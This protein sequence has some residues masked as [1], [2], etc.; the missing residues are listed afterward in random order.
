MEKSRTAGL[1]LVI[2]FLVSF[3][4]VLGLRFWSSGESAEI[5]GPVH[6]AAGAAGV[7]VAANDELFVLSSAGD[8]RAR[9]RMASLM[10]PRQLIDL[11][12]LRDGR[13]LL[14]RR[15]P[16]A[17]YACEL[18]RWKCRELL[19]PV[20][21]HLR[22]QYKVWPDENANRLLISDFS[23]GQLWS[24]PLSG[25]APEALTEKG[26][27][28]G[29]N[30][31]ALDG[32]GRLW[33]ADSAGRRLV[34]LEP[35][36]TGAWQIEKHLSARSAIA[37]EN[38]NWPMMLALAPDGNWWVTQP[39]PDSRQADLLIY[40][41]DKGVSARV[42][43]PAEAYPTDV[44]AQG[45]SMLVTDMDNFRVY[46]VDVATRK[47]GEFGDANF[48]GALQQ[49]A[50]RKTRYQAWSDQ[51]LIGAIVFGVLMVAAAV[52][53]TPKDKRWS[54]REST[55]PL[56][57]SSAP[58]PALQTIHWL[59]RNP[60]TARTLRWILPMSYAAVVLAIAAFAAIYFDLFPGGQHE[61]SPEKLR[62]L[63]ELKSQLLLLA[64]LMAGV[65]IL[66]HL[67]VRN[68]QRRLGTNG[69]ALFVKFTDGRQLSLAP[70]QLVYDNRQ[71]CY[72]DC[73][74]PIRTGKQQPLYEAGEIETFVAPL[75]ARARKLDALQMLRYQFVNREP[76][77]IAA[78]L[79][80]AVLGFFLAA[81]GAW[82]KLIPGLS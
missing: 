47:V 29:P 81:T 32:S 2:L 63:A 33:V 71:I 4:G 46:R 10:E 51:S 14:A 20:S 38:H 60:R 21:R 73:S 39:T 43:L 28:R 19:Y 59:K 80:I 66:M 35:T 11:R 12:V 58:A 56:A 44:A 64:A 24:Q 62:K 17:L 48:R 42:G 37:G 26:D 23:S 79:F 68:M 13:L 54:K 8:V 57:A 45:G 76:L 25:G 5:T 53:A 34:A 16:A 61:L 55:A 6:I 50:A 27:L 40:D 15:D 78:L 65:P 30:D 72:R 52:R 1:A 67:G 18:A 9:H 82:H 31:L 22:D 3:I 70:E 41:P 77:L 7:V 75:L 69:Y 36:A 49:A 74:F